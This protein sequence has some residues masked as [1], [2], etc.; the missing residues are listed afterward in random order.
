MSHN[1]PVPDPTARLQAAEQPAADT[2]PQWLHQ[3]FGK[4]LH[5]G[6]YLPWEQTEEADRSY[7]EHEAAAVRRAVARGGFKPQNSTEDPAPAIP[8]EPA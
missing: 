5:G 6:D 8:G 7:W 4:Y 2:L 3:R 1:H